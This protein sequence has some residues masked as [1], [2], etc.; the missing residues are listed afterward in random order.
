MI[1]F[2]ICKYIWMFEIWMHEIFFVVFYWN[3]IY[4]YMQLLFIFLFFRRYEILSLK[5]YE[6]MSW[7]RFF[8][9]IIIY[10]QHLKMSWECLNMCMEFYLRISMNMYKWMHDENTCRKYIFFHFWLLNDDMKM[11]ITFFFLIWECIGEYIKTIFFYLL[12]ENA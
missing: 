1:F 2:K 12:N 3:S 6:W 11:Q 10:Y 5:M 8:V 4:E 7:D 9:I